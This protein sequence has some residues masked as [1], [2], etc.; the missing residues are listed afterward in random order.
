[1]RF[2]KCVEVYEIGKRSDGQG[3]Y[4]GNKSLYKSI[5]CNVSTLRVEK[6][7]QLF[8]V[9]NYDSLNL[10]TM[11]IID[12]NNFCILIGDKYYKPIHKPKVV[13]NKTYITLDVLE[14]AN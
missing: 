8:G 12:I 11:D 10:T 9:V 4:I 7:I 14:H 2:D 5:Y 6:Q 1:M 3:G 13:K